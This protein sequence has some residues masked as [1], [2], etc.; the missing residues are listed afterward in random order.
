VALS[1][2]CC[3]SATESGVCAEVHTP[4]RGTY[5]RRGAVG[6][7]PAFVALTLTHCENR[8]VGA[9]FINGPLITTGAVFFYKRS[10]NHYWR[11]L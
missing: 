7:S 9:L 5:A 1:L 2:T 8:E 11:C 10:S 3:E 6:A 4:E